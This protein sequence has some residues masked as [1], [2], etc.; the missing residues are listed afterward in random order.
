MFSINGNIDYQHTFKKPGQLLTLSY[1]IST[2]PTANES[3]FRIINDTIL[4]AIGVVD[5]DRRTASRTHG[6]EHTGQIDYIEPFQDGMHTME[7]GLKYIFRSNISNNSYMLFNPVTQSYDIKDPD[8]KEQDMKYYQHVFGAYGSYTFRLQKFS[9]RVGAR[10]E[11]NVQDV[12]FID[13]E[14]SGFEA[15]YM[16]IVPSVSLN[17]M[18]APA[19]SLSLSYNNSISRPSIFHLNPYVERVS[20]KIIKYGNPNLK[21]ERSHN[22]SLSYGLYSQ[23][24]NLNLSLDGGLVNN[25]ITQDHFVSDDGVYH[26]TFNNIGKNY[27]AG[28]NAFISYN[29]AQWLSMWFSGGPRYQYFHNLDYKVGSLQSNM[30]AG[31]NFRLPWNLK[32]SV[33]GGGMTPHKGYK[34]SFSGYYYYY[35]S[36]GRGFLKNDQLNV[37]ISVVNPHAKYMNYQM[38]TFDDTFVFTGDTSHRARQIMINVSWRFGEMKAKIAKAERGIENTDLKEGGNKGAGG[39]AGGATGGGGIG[40]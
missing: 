39:Q 4:P 32:F 14:Q 13:S 33:G 11:G 25:A 9:A 31:M 8:Q 7:V 38:S 17:Y 15:K 21:S 26:I 12:D 35:A 36:L 18:V 19:M 3:R 16:D 23:K 29:P 28:L 5:R 24:V 34:M 2:E 6:T 1:L 20:D 10:L 30:F 40:M 22:L 27:S 37:N